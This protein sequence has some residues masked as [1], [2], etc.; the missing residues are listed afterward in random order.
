DDPTTD[1]SFMPPLGVVALDGLH[2]AAKA[3]PDNPGWVVLIGPGGLAQAQIHRFAGAQ[4]VVLTDYALNARVTQ[5][6]LANNESVS[7]RTFGIRNT[8]ILTGAE[9]LTLQNKLPLPDPAQGATLILDGLYP[10][11]Q[12]GQVAVVSGDLFDPTG[13]G[14]TAQAAT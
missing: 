9:R 3:T 12:D 2:D 13:A 6:I 7:N 10:N 1:P 11:L 5:L 4:P 8:L 14:A